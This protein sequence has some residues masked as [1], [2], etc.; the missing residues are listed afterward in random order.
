MV[1][2][3]R[4]FKTFDLSV[5]LEFLLKICMSGVLWDGLDEHVVV[6]KLF[7]VGTKKLLVELECSALLTVNGEVFHFFGCVVE[8]LGIL[9]L[10]D[11]RIEWSGNVSS[12]LWLDVKTDASNLFESIS[13]FG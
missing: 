9:D 1:T 10:D 7:L 2:V 11:T 3:E 4:N 8:F 12:D 5:F 13:K 6:Q